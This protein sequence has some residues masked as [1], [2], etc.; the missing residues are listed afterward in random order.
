MI[1]M[2][3]DPGSE[4]VAVTSIG[5]LPITQQLHVTEDPQ[6][7]RTRKRF[8]IIL[9]VLLVRIKKENMFKLSS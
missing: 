2:Q 3:Y 7:R 5:Y 1:N 9:G 8:L 6:I 4:K